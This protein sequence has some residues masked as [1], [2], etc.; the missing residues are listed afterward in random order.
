LQARIQEQDRIHAEQTAA[1]HAQLEAQDR[2][3][4]EMMLI[5]QQLGQ[6]MG[7]LV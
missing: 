2:R 6:K 7:V 3:M 1:L 5:V 4:A